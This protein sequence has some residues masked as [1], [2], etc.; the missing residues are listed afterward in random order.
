MQYLT[1][2]AAIEEQIA[3][4]ALTPNQKLPS[5]RQ[6]A[7]SFSTTR[8][9]LREAL[10]QLEKEGK[11]YRQDRRGWYISTPALYFD[12]TSPLDFEQ[13]AQRQARKAHSELLSAETVLADRHATQLLSLPAF[14]SMH[15]LTFL[16]YLNN[17]PLAFDTIY[18]NAALCKDL[19]KE[20]LLIPLQLLYVERF[21]IVPV[22]VSFQI[23]ANTLT[24]AKAQRL[25]ASE[26]ALGIKIEKTRLTQE[27]KAIDASITYWRNNAIHIGTEHPIKK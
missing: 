22:Q 8:I 3:G 6:L 5:E 27:G 23:S 4:G 10:G 14:S 12:P 13:I 9:T 2:K 11:I 24:G 18:I 19:L 1:I 7:E 26:G 21:K 17:I 25:L 16:R 20:D 15:K